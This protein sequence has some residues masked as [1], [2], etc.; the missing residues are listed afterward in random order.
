MTVR[1]TLY[2]LRQPLQDPNQSL[3]PSTEDAH[4]AGTASLVLLEQAVGSAPAF[5]GPV[6]VLSSESVAPGTPA[7]TSVISYRDLVALIAEH[8]TTI[9]L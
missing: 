3:F 4:A 2:L 8:E 6:Y 5:P 1:K 9:V 7:S